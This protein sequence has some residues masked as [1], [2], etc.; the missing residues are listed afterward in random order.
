MSLADFVQ[1]MVPTFYESILFTVLMVSLY[2]LCLL[3]FYSTVE[4][5]VKTDSRCYRDMQSAT[6]TGTYTATASNQ[7]GEPLYAV[8]YN[9]GAKSF[10]VNCAC[11]AGNVANTYPNIDV[12]NL[13]TQQA[14]RIDN[15]MCS[16]DK[17]YYSPSYDSIYFSGYPGVTR[18]MN[19]ASTIA[20]ESDV[21][22]KADTSFFQT[23][24]AGGTY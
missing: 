3:F 20:S 13:N 17:Q 22:T 15:K 12:Y 2:V 7:R 5:Q 23:A 11:P 1:T 6:S 16:C 14:Q 18:Y 8:S 10:A 9:M 4:L 19:S 21:K 24:L